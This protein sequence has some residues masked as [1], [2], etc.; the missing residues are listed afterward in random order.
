VARRFPP[1]LAIA[2]WRAARTASGKMKNFI[3]FFKLISI[4]VVTLF[5]NIIW[6]LVRDLCTPE[7][8]FASVLLIDTPKGDTLEPSL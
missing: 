3:M 4:S 6:L 5:Y 7:F 1:A 2:V 8:P